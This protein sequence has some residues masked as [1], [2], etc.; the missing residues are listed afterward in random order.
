MSLFNPLQHF[1]YANRQMAY[2]VIDDTVLKTTNVCICESYREAL[3]IASKVPTRKVIPLPFYAKVRIPIDYVMP[4]P[5]KVGQI[6]E[7]KAPKAPKPNPG[8]PF[9]RFE[10][11][12]NPGNS[13]PGFEPKAPKP[14]PGNPFPG[15]L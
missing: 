2:L 1:D 4:Q 11:K 3:A 5:L 8:N 7:P 12:P 9:P 10:P 6:F 15:Y 13:F 14:N